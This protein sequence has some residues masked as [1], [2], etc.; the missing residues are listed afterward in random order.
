MI[1]LCLPQQK[2]TRLTPPT[3]VLTVDKAD[4]LILQDTLQ[5]IEKMVE[6]QEHVV[7]DSS[8]LRND[9]HNIPDTREKGK[10]VEESRI[11]PFPTPIRSPWIHTDLISLD[12]EKL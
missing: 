8:I 4:E 3:P 9:E 5:E 7:D 12:T 2:S 10:N 1:R 6:G 11:T